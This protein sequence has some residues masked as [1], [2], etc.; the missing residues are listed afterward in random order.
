M[1]HLFFDMPLCSHCW[2]YD[3]G[4]GGAMEGVGRFDIPSYTSL[5]QKELRRLYLAAYVHG[6]LWNLSLGFVRSLVVE[7]RMGKHYCRSERPRR[8]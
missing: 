5:L 1:F 3:D 8:L 6:I 7:D 2:Y 4:D